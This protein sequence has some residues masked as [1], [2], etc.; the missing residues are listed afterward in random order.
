MCGMQ[1]P[2][3]D[4]KAVI[5]KTLGIVGAGAIGQAL[6]RGL[7][8]G[9]A[10]YTLWA[11]TRTPESAAR[12]EREFSITATD[13]YDRLVPATN[14][15]LLCVKPAQVE[16]ALRR[17]SDAGLHQD[18]LVI[19]VAAGIPIAE[20]ERGL[21]DRIAVIRAMPNVPALVGEAMT[22][23]ARG[24]HATKEQ[25][26]E[27]TQ[28]FKTVGRCVE[29]AEQYLN[30]VTAISGCGPAYVFLIIEALADAGVSVGLPRDVARELVAQ[31]VLGAAKMVQDSERHPAAMRDDVATP[32][33]C[34][35]GALLVLEDGKIRS[36]L[37]R[38][39]NEATRI[40][41]TLGQRSGAG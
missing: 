12:I 7:K 4:R 37:A 18:A 30:A 38:A 23:I 6:L 16:G 9:A 34:T 26:D 40:A 32:A 1:A 5:M 14:V 27:A 41:A 8:A 15:V 21:G 10:P 20:L 11:A 36:V 39:I 19:S 17:L 13:A 28:I 22:V 29:L 31:T 33:G 35:I 3:L 25:V 2:S 24:R